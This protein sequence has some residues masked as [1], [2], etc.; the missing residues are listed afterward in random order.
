M[1]RAV[2]FGATCILF[3]LTGFS[4]GAQETR[5]DF[6]AL[7]ETLTDEMDEGQGQSAWMEELQ[8]LFENPVNINR[9]RRDELLRIPF[10]NEVTTANILA[11]RE[12]SGPFLTVYELASVEGVGPDLAS[13]LSWFVYTGE[14]DLPD[15]DS[16]A[17]K[18]YVQQ[19][20][21]LKGWQTIPR[22]QGY[23][24]NDDKPPAFLGTPPKIY[25]RYQYRQ[26]NALQAGLTADKD[27]GEPFFSGPNRWGFDFYSAHLELRVNEKFTQL[28]LGDYTVRAGQGLVMW[29]GFSMGKSA[30]GLQVSRPTSQIRPYSS[31]DENF[32]FRGVAS[33]FRKGIFVSHVFVSSKK[34][35][36]NIDVGEDGSKTFSSLQSS[37]YHRT[38]SEAEDKNSIRHSLAGAI[39]GLTTGN[40]HLGVNMLYER[41]QYPM[42]RGEQLY[43]Q[44][45]F[46]GRE[47]HNISLDYRWINGAFHFF[48]ELALSKSGGFAGIQG[49][50]ALLH[51]Q[52]KMAL[53]FRH[54]Q[55][56]YQATWAGA[57]GENGRAMNETGF[58]AGFRALPFSRI[59]LSGY[60][61]W[62][63]SPWINYSTS[64]PSHGYDYA[65][66]ADLRL[67]RRVT[68][69]LRLKQKFK[70][71]KSKSGYVYADWPLSRTSMRIHGHFQVSKNFSLRS[72]VEPVW[73][74]YNM[75][76]SGILFL[77][78][79][80][81]S[82][83]GK[84]F[85]ASARGSWFASDGYN[86]RIY[87]FEND[88]LYNF[89]TP[90]FFGKGT[91]AYLNLRYRL[92]EGLDFWF[93]VGGTL[94]SD[95]D[96]IS[97]G[98][99]EIRGNSKTEV[100]IQMRCRF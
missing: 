81:W 78:D 16:S 34:S 8:L 93:K 5:N 86:S 84:A 41:F 88:L 94:Y 53:I 31:S 21:L 55:K 26:G 19:Q 59:T 74:Q 85:S 29:Q 67:T 17:V 70:M 79:V 65:L 33:T 14:N 4:L 91:R 66:Q 32:F 22:S 45:M 46:K 61:D 52:F 2:K 38:I 72:R 10:L 11:Y 54:Y 89:S 25:A 96:V 68:F 50:E 6:E 28:I 80:V 62:F 24:S 95:R 98:H 40:L 92:S 71:D 57:F 82:P 37:G 49:M 44:Y 83:P 100:K 1:K 99:S 12:K 60:A 15:R 18:K 9:A 77:Q 27:P 58:Y 87:A 73:Y 48:G 51:D 43:Q 56:N 30:D 63:W 7:L 39:V 23:F 97:S 90:S 3:I 20:V 42:F 13:K 64:G 47:N 75:K 69:Y 36:G 35:D 76:E